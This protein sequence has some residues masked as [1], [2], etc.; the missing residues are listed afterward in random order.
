MPDTVLLTGI[1]GFLGGHIA[2]VL[3]NAG[4]KVRGS[5]RNLDR[6]EHVKKTLAAHGGNVDNLEFVALDLL[7]G[8]GWD[9]AM[10]GVKFLMHTASPFVLNM[11]KDRMD[12]IRPA[13]EGT[14]RAINAA[15]AAK[16]ERIVL[17][18]SVIAITA[19]HLTNRPTHFTAE[20]WTNYQ[21]GNVTAYA[22]SK[23]RA[24]EKAWELMKSA[25]RISDLT[26]INPGFIMGPVLDTDPGTSGELILRIMQGELPAAPDIEFHVIDVRDVATIHANALTEAQTFG[27]RVPTIS[28]PVTMIEFGK[29]I[30]NALPTYKSKMPK[31]VAPN[32]LIRIMSIF[33]PSVSAIVPDLGHRAEMDNADARLILGQEMI[34]QEQSVVA[35][36]KSLI[37][38]KLI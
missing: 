2:L 1:S 12:L 21:T 27:K 18:S 10:Q 34:A 3:L 33:D 19:G 14:T 11:P 32:W 4:Y 16:V 31:F 35:L 15:L 25:D 17:T 8:D 37:E 20:H 24:E 22:E 7:K 29:F 5:V 6:A 9:E 36:A 28:G 30:G 13:V 23:T 26:V 38:Q